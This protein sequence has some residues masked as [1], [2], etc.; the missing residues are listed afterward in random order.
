ML[1]W[2]IGENFMYK[3]KFLLFAVLAM[4]VFTLTGAAIAKGSGEKKRVTFK[5]RVENVADKDGVLAQDGSHYPFALS[6]GFYIVT[7]KKSD[8]FTV[9]KRADVELERQA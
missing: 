5:V 1:F 9:G 8:L 2:K 6:P 7:N 3:Q 4:S